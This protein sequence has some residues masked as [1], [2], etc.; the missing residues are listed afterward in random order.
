MAR[1]HVRS[2][3]VGYRGLLPDDYLDGL[4]PEDRAG[5][6]SF[7]SS[8]PR[9]PATLVALTEGAI[10]GFVTTVPARDADAAGKGEIAGLYVDP[11]W[12][13]G[14]IGAALMRAG[15]EHLGWQGFESALLW[16]LD[17]NTRAQRFYGRDGWVADGMRRWEEIWGVTVQELRYSRPLP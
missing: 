10:T 13:G 8:D 1:V 17:S 14:G 4:R 15:R 7:G 5:R 16:V 11:D 6:Y 9:R 2:W 12:W 3:Q